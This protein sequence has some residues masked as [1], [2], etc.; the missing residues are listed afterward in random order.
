M[1]E[2]MELDRLNAIDEER[3]LLGQEDYDPFLVEG[4]LETKYDICQN[5]RYNYPGKIPAVNEGVAAILCQYC[6]GINSNYEPVRPE[7]RKVLE[8]KDGK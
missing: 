5:C 4:E 6:K 2:F 7:E 3:E 1:N 8:G